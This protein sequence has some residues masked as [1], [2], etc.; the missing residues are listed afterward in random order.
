[1]KFILGFFIKMSELDVNESIQERIN[2][3]K[4]RRIEELNARLRK[5]LLRERISASNA[6]YLII[7]YTKET[8]DYLVPSLWPMTTEQNK[9]RRSRQTIR[10]IS[11]SNDVGCCTIT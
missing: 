4:L 3:I 1:M 10:P 6:S 11:N 9:Y 5:T 2:I 8:P 7:N